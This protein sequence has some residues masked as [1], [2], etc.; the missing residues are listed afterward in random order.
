MPLQAT[1]NKKIFVI[2]WHYLKPRQTY[3][4]KKNIREFVAQKIPAHHRDF[5]CLF[6]LISELGHKFDSHEANVVESVVIF[7][8]FFQS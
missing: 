6:F 4:A 2:S 7:T 5:L 8:K 3:R 1:K